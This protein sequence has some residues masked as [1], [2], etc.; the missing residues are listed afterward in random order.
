MKSNS[1]RIQNLI[2]FC[3]RLPDEALE[4]NLP[5]TLVESLAKFLKQ[6]VDEYRMRD[7]HISVALARSIIQLGQVSELPSI[8]AL[9]HMAHG[10]ALALIE[11][12]SQAWDEL[13][14]AEKLFEDAEDHVG[15]ARTRIGL[16]YLATKRSV[17]ERLEIKETLDRAHQILVD[18]G[19]HDKSLVLT[20]NTAIAYDLL[21]NHTLSLETYQELLHQVLQSNDTTKRL[22]LGMTYTNIAVT[23][24]YLGMGSN[25]LNYH[26][27]A[28]S[29][30]E[31]FEQ[32]DGVTRQ[33]I[34]TTYVLARQ[35]QYCTAIKDL[36]DLLDSDFVSNIGQK[37]VARRMLAEYYLILGRHNKALYLI[38]EIL[39]FFLSEKN[40]QEAT[41]I[42]IRKA[43][44][45]SHLHLYD[46]AL[47]ELNNAEHIAKQIDAVFQSGTIYRHRAGLFLTLGNAR[48]AGDEAS[49]AM[50]VFEK[51]NN[52]FELTLASLY[53]IACDIHLNKLD[54][55][56]DQLE[57]IHQ[58]CEQEHLPVLSYE[59]WL[60][61]A[62]LDLA[63]DDHAQ[64]EIS[65][66]KAIDII[67]H[68]Q[69]NLTITLRP[70]FL[71]GRTQPYRQLIRLYL[72]EDNKKAA[73]EIIERIRSQV[74]MTYLLDFQRVR[75]QVSED[76]VFLIEELNNLRGRYHTLSSMAISERNPSD[77]KQIAAQ[78][79]DI[80]ERLYLSPQQSQSIN[81]LEIPAWDETQSHLQTN[82][83]LLTYY[84]DDEQIY[85]FVTSNDNE[86][87][88][89]ELGLVSDIKRLVRQFYA[90]IN[91]ILSR[92]Q[93][94]DH[95]RHTR[96]IIRVLSRLYDI[97]LRPIY[98]GNIQWQAYR[99]M[100]VPYG[101][102]HQVPFACLHDG[103]HYLVQRSEIVNL[104]NSGWLTQ[105]NRTP[106][107]GDAVVLGHSDNGRLPRRLTEAQGV[108]K[109]LQTIAHIEEKAQ[110]QVFQTQ[111][112]TILHIAAHAEFIL[113][114]PE[115]SH[116]QLGDGRWHVDDLL[117][118]DLAFQL[119]TLGA[120]ETGGAAVAPGDE[121]IGMGHSFL[122]SGSEAVIASLWRVE[123]G[124]TNR[125]MSELYASLVAG[126][127]KSEA[128]RRA[129]LSL[130]ESNPDLHPVF[131]GAWQM[132]GNARPIQW[133]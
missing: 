73:L 34:N 119:V 1:F 114:E 52:Q 48:L 50:E 97:L 78:I 132:I 22:Y 53:K 90:G 20:S 62:E 67:S 102:L 96:Q 39:P 70:L 109:I 77:L 93:D 4:V 68:L 19:L 16:I 71:K 91:I 57:H 42:Y 127:S 56:H 51:S 89:F 11:E 54:G 126:L 36:H 38:N 2:E 79:K 18:N 112:G 98:E 108:A 24:D 80:R 49:K 81:Y 66:K 40:L 117:Q 87:L 29:T 6:S 59:A 116:I 74:Y 88:I 27:L 120:C 111:C 25:A 129:Q 99:H 33:I 14:A 133:N 12:T 44:A 64:T 21:G 83:I 86:P 124:Q 28:R 130:L 92:E 60:L 26:K 63:N 15:W 113:S 47:N 69:D 122:F 94:R 61:Q 82:E 32:W 10:D 125:L 7:P 104:P 3:T 106:I 8:Q 107:I 121:L 37:H 123:D 35:G 43:E 65:L 84:H 95:Q 101:A 103:D 5:S 75:W 128:L 105:R 13:K 76:N 31:T 58:F 17:A 46:D 55:L 45:L 85:L 131:W 110:S 23:Y 118:S 115:L 30:F 41:K 72:Q 9:G 100:I